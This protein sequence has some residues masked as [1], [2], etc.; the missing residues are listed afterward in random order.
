[1]IDHPSREEVVAVYEGGLSPER[2]REVLSHLLAPCALC[3][4]AAAA[5]MGLERKEALAEELRIPSPIDETSYDAAIQRAIGAALRQERFL[6]RQRTQARRALRVLESG[7]LAALQKLPRGLGGLA[8][9]EAFLA[10]SWQLRHDDPQL[11][12]QF[13]WLAAQ[14]SLRLD[15]RDFDR[16]ERVC[17]F[18]ARAHAEWGNACRAANRLHEAGGILGRARQLFERGTLDE[19]L[20]I[21]VLE[22][23]ASL[24]ADRS[25]F[26]RASATLLKVADFH[27]RHD[28]VHLVGR[29]LVQ[30]GLY[31]GY[32]GNHEKG[33]GL[34][35]K[36]LAL[37]DAERDPGLA[38]ISAHNLILLLVESGRFREAKTQRLIYARN[39]V[40]A[41][42]RINEIKFRVLEAQIDTGLGNYP[43]AVSIFREVIAG[44][45]EAQL[46]ILASIERLH[47]AACLLA[48]GKA[49]EASGVILEAVEIFTRLEIQ[50]EALQ[51]VILLRNA[52][53]ME[54]ATLEMVEEVAEFLRRL[55]IDPAL[56][57]EGR[58]WED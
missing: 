30:L 44:F 1:M 40:N 7:G 12:V 58:A 18:Q 57:F 45:E 47:L 17:D 33:I 15:P 41:G 54:K 8:R 55:Q 11:M 53:E 14:V 16:S 3:L 37:I 52:V 24:A 50:V 32:S 49:R 29:T 19:F 20:E 26:G 36:S 23:E 43:R 13:A 28:D 34:L 35:E 51:A 25:E 39:L 6:R 46:P 56:R 5:P 9:M 10:R 42:G 31:A 2:E 27:E 22:L 4:A 38:C 21:R 48:W